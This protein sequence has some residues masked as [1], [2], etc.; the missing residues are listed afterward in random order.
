MDV[1]TLQQ[2]K[3]QGDKRYGTPLKINTRRL[4]ARLNP[5]KGTS[6]L[7]H[8]SP[9]TVSWSSTR[10]LS[11]RIHYP[12]SPEVTNLGYMPNWDSSTGKAHT[13]SSTVGLDFYLTGDTV[14][15]GW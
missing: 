2:A 3:T 9:P 8:S 5:A 12:M 1:V 11:S 6:P 13:N 14:E 7:I 15:I 4:L 10:T